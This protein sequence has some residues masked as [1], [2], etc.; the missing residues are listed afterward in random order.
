MGRD[1][2]QEDIYYDAISWHDCTDILQ[3]M[4]VHAL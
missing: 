1:T 2:Q 4:Q 3:D